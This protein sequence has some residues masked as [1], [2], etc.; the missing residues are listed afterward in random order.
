MLVQRDFQLGLTGVIPRYDPDAML[1]EQFSGR[2]VNGRAIGW[3]HDLFEKQ[4]D[5]GRANVSQEA[6]LLN[7]RPILYGAAPSVQGFKPDIRQHTHFVDV[8]LKR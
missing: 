2:R 8:W 6:R 1:G 3:R 7:E 5:Q 4:L